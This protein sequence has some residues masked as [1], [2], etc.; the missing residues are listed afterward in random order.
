M[1]ATLF[2]ETLLSD[3]G[4]HRH[5]TT[6]LFTIQMMHALIARGLQQ[7]LFSD[8]A[9]WVRGF[10]SHGW[11]TQQEQPSCCKHAMGRHPARWVLFGDHAL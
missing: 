1:Q 11:I 10:A 2:I 8:Q 4:A 3:C 6:C 7:R 5:P 9:C